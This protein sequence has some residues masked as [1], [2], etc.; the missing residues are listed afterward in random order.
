M[1]TQ[2]PTGSTSESRVATAILL[3]E[4]GLAGHGHDL[5]DA[6]VDL[7]DLGLEQLLD[8]VRR[9]AAQDDH[10]A[11]R[12]AVDA[13]D[14]R[15]DAIA[16]AVRLARGLLAS[17][18]GRPRCLTQVDDDV[19]TLLEAPDD[20]ADELALA[21]LVLVE[22]DVA[23]GVAHALEQH[24][25]GG[26]RGDAAERAARLLHVEQAAELFVLLASALG[27]ARVPENLKAEL[28]ARVR[29]EAVLA[30]RLERDLALGL[31]HAL[32]HG[33][34]LKEIDAARI[35]VEASFELT[36]GTEGRLRRL[37]DRRLH[38]LDEHLL[39]DALLLGD[40]FNDAAQVFTVARRLCC[41]LTCSLVAARASRATRFAPSGLLASGASARRLPFEDQVGAVDVFEIERHGLASFI[42]ESHAPRIVHALQSA[43]HDILAAERNL[44]LQAR[45]LP[46]EANVIIA[47]MSARSTPGDPT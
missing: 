34:V 29:F 10:R 2:A 19:V 38:R 3:R 31:G 25:L 28:L 47:V 43:A 35:R 27:V 33:H 9:A 40:R 13:L 6:L 44:E 14:E 37:Q 4:P 20:A 8:Q 42:L 39:V 18:A 26:L 23:L 16:R 12:L 30:R 1:P 45:E 46:R 24:L 7:G 21:I 32:D 36:G 15:H 11:A 41:H 17:R 5:D 22:D